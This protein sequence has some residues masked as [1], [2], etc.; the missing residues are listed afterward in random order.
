[1]SFSDNMKLR[2]NWFYI[3]IYL[4]IFHFFNL[5]YIIF[6]LTRAFYKHNLVSSI[7]FKFYNGNTK[8][9]DRLQPEN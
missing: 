2:N 6:K 8:V 3:Y 4:L 7:L 9:I 1:M 5:A